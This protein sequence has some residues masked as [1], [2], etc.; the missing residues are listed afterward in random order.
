MDAC[1]HL[2]DLESLLD[3][4][5]C[6]SQIE[7]FK[8]VWRALPPAMDT[9]W[10]SMLIGDHIPARGVRRHN[11]MKCP[12]SLTSSREAVHCYITLYIRFHGAWRIC[13]GC[14]HSSTVCAARMFWLVFIMISTLDLPVFLSCTYALPFTFY[15]IL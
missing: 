6:T 15:Y 7:V 14:H 10:Q 2:V 11:M 13:F 3:F 1:G 5:W 9:I 4:A 8:K 12:W